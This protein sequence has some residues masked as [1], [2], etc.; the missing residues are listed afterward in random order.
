[1][2]MTNEMFN[3]LVV[4]KFNK[5]SHFS[6]IQKI[7]NYCNVL[8][9][10]RDFSNFEIICPL[11]WIMYI[12]MRINVINWSSSVL[13]ASTIKR[14]FG[15]SPFVH[16]TNNKWTIMDYYNNTYGMDDLYNACKELGIKHAYETPCSTKNENKRKRND[17][18]INTKRARNI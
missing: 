9:S 14:C 8:Y 15:D 18:T 13:L 7:E 3:T 4:D 12:R 1:M 10:V 6:D 2:I 17:A 5:M 16:G 11:E